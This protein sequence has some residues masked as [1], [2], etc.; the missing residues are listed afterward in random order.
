MEPIRRKRLN[1]RARGVAATIF[2]ED[3]NVSTALVQGVTNL[4]T[5]LG[6]R[7]DHLFCQTEISSKTQ[8]LH[9]QL[10]IY[11]KSPIVFTS[12]KKIFSTAFIDCEAPHIE[13]TEHS[14]SVNATY[15]Q[16]ERT[17][18][19]DHLAFTYAS[20]DMPKQGKRND[21]HD[22]V[23]SLFASGEPITV[24]EALR[25]D[26]TLALALKYPRALAA[27]NTNI[28][29]SFTRAKPPCVVILHGSTGSG[30]NRFIHDNYALHWEQPISNSKTIWYD[31]YLGQSTVFFDE[32]SADTIM[33]INILKRL[34]DRYPVML[35]VKG[36][37]VYFAPNIIFFATND[38]YPPVSWFPSASIT[39]IAALRR[40]IV[41]TQDT[42][43]PDWQEPLFLRITDYFAV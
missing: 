33:P 35:P 3:P 43:E 37:H 30:K 14:P 23:R 38:E 25:D 31:G 19:T 34:I 40:R 15:C 7:I 26:S 39:D 22:A 12:W 5:Q 17:R 9:L 36:G 42:D 2:P 32:A 1:R 21:I 20:G 4:R 16:K 28:I 8:R 18:C 27:I 10:F 11:I 29:A 41:F 24:G 6:V 13:F